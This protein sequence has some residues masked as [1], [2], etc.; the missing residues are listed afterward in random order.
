L[1]SHD[2]R[3]GLGLGGKQEAHVTHCKVF[4]CDE[5]EGGKYSLG[6]YSYPRLSKITIGVMWLE[7]RGQLGRYC[8]QSMG[9]CYSQ[10]WV[11]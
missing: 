2:A 6:S 3:I 10:G 7:M 4:I 8:Q 1:V 11:L 5:L 9:K